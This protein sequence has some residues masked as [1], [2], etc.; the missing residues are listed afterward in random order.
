MDSSSR[1]KP[2]VAFWA[3]VVVVA[4]LVAYPLSL[5]PACWLAAREN[6]E[7]DDGVISDLRVT[8]HF[9]W[10]LG[11]AAANA[12]EPVRDLVSWYAT[13]RHRHVALPYT[14]QGNEHWIARAR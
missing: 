11:W 6:P 12:P 8:S 4:I 9:Y 1:Q 5:G 10:P 2:G 7:L 3:T 13:L 14:R